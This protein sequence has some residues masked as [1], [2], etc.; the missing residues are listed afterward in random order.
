MYR[1]LTLKA[2]RG[3]VDLLNE[4]ALAKLAR[5]TK[6]DLKN[7]GGI[8]KVYLDGEDVTGLIRNQTGQAPAGGVLSGFQVLNLHIEAGGGLD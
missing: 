4:A 8:L 1:A 6:I 5:S 3:G 7:E 2:M